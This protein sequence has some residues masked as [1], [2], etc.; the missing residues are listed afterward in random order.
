MAYKS[1]S[2]Y[3]KTDFDELSFNDETKAIG[4]KTS[5]EAVESSLLTENDRE[6]IN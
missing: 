2:R 3:L 5:L 4:H 6:G 1:G